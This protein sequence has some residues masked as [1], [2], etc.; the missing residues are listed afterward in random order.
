M[1]NYQEMSDHEISCEVGRKI[2]FADYIMARNGQVN[3][4]NSWADAGPIVQENRISLFASDDDVKWMAQFINH[5]NV[6]MD[7][8]PLRAAM[9]VFLMMKGGE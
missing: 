1:M 2:S 3:Y 6:H 5:K 4:C 9:V 7:K 8:N